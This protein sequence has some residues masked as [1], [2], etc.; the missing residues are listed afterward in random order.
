M[1]MCTPDAEAVVAALDAVE[2]AWDKLAAL[3]VHALGAGQVLAVLSRLEIHRRRQPITEHALL[4]HLQ[5]QA[6]PKEMGAKSWRAV[7]SNRLGISGFDAGRR[8]VEAAQPAQPPN[9]SWAGSQ[10]D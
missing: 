8:I 9:P 4:T 7:L 5:T 6:T 3:P 10:A 2:A 1:E